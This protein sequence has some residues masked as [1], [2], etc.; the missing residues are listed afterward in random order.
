MDSVFGLRRICRTVP[1]KMRPEKASTRN[2][3]AIPARIAPTSA[4]A[5]VVSI[6]ICARFWAM[7]KICGADRLAATVCPTSTSRDMT[8]P[9]TG[10]RMT[11]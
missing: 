1:W 3:A 2:T 5:T 11:A 10:E 8:T 9:A 4:S 6:C 7:E